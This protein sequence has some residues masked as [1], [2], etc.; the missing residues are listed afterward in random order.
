MD[1]EI[2]VLDQHETD[3]SVVTHDRDTYYV[4][5]AV[6]AVLRDS[7]GRIALMYSSRRNYYKLPGGGVDND[8]DLEDALRRELLEEVGATVIINDELGQV[9]EWRDY[10]NF[11]QISHAYTATLKGDSVTP[12]LTESE[13]AEGF[14][15]RWI[16]DLGE[17]IRLV[18]VKSGSDD[19]DVSFMCRRD[20]AILR[21]VK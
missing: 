12:S 20:T 15:V 2:T 16:V 6:R 5:T 17:A 3:P 10:K 1:K 4:R 18:D 19:L 7:E 14:E 11:K 9:V 13:I 8:E 21:A